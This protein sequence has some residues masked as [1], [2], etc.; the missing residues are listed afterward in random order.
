MAA[1]SRSLLNNNGQWELAGETI[2]SKLEVLPGIMHL[3]GGNEREKL[4]TMLSG[5]L[6]TNEELLLF[7]DALKKGDSEIF[8]GLSGEIEKRLGGYPS[9]S[10]MEDLPVDVH[11]LW[12]NFAVLTKNNA[13]ERKIVVQFE[14]K[15]HDGMG[16]A[17]RVRILSLS[18]ADILDAQVLA[19]IAGSPREQNDTINRILQQSKGIISPQMMYARKHAS[20]TAAMA[21]RSMDDLFPVVSQQN[22]QSETADRQGALAAA[23]AIMADR[24]ADRGSFTRD[25]IEKSVGIGSNAVYEAM[26]AAL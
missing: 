6:R 10:A 3:L 24:L 9:E 5:E 23:L 15:V 1:A 25:I 18:M 4:A 21:D 8:K 14:R 11:A 26:L 13:Q 12:L 20:A 16:D 2:A 7:A 22:S 17:D 19:A